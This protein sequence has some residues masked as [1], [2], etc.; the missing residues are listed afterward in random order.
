ME[1]KDLRN[2]V[3]TGETSTA[4]WIETL[5]KESSNQFLK[6]QRD[7]YIN[8]RFARGDH[9]IIYNKSLNKIQSLPVAEG[10]IRRTV[11]KVKSQIRGVKNFIKRNQPRWEVHPLGVEDEDHSTALKENKI[12]QYIYR[13][14]RVKKLLTDQIV[15]SLKYSVGV[16]EGGVIKKDG[17][18]YLDFWIDDT[19]DVVFDPSAT[20]VQDCRFIFK[21][22]KKPISAIKE[23]YKVKK[24]AS[25]NKEAASEYKDILEK[26]KYSREENKGGDDLQTAIVTELWMKWV[27]SDGKVKVRVITTT[28]NQ[29]LKV[30]DTAYRRYPIFVY[31][32]EKESNSIY[33][34]PWI[35]DLISLNKSL[36][37]TTSQIEGY[38]Q[39]MLAGKFLIKQGVEVTTITDKGAEHIYYKGSTPPSQL[40]LQPLPSAPYQHLTNLER[41]IE[42]L[43][44]VR[45]ASLGRAPGSLQSG[46]AIE[47]LQSADAGV[48]SEPVENL[49]LMLEDVAEFIL[50]V[51]SD[52]QLTS[53]TI[54]EDGEE[55]KFIGNV[56]GEAPEDTTKV[57]PGKVKVVIVPEIA[58][59]EEAKKEWIMR[60]AEAQL[61]D[62][63]TVL[64]RFNF[65]NISQTLERMKKRKDEDFK[66][67]M[68][69]QRESHR[70]DGNAP[71]DTADLANQENMQMA[72]GQQVALTPQVLWT[73]EH[74]QLHMAFIQENQDAYTQNEELFTEHIQAE[75]AYATQ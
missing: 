33:S 19:F 57:K 15:N 23:K 31:N 53:E 56:E 52:F 67:D 70:T 71:D 37:K 26:E 29:V 9:W 60:L 25:D 74:L 63:E 14:R 40:N 32:P 21:T 54:V 38:I 28:S 22:F 68:V 73:P 1:L 44:G 13:T 50:E 30:F 16:L 5:Y 59:T 6:Q 39:R 55:I 2:E 66:E 58:Y 18:D 49:E 35:K 10:E 62:P 24:V 34:D 48:V 47:A 8:A 75:E 12:L 61:I 27:E 20:S 7:W 51:L 72:A 45:E 69:K 65:S 46:K 36:D 17:K 3:K 41:W 43:G 11:N 42:E 64:E 4:K